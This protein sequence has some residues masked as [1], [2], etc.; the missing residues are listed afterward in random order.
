MLKIVKK[1]K[2]KKRKKTSIK[3]VFKNIFFIC[4]NFFQIF[5]KSSDLL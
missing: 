4:S 3:L 1:K 5:F 2:K